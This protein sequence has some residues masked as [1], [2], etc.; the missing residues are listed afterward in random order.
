M[1]SDESS[2]CCTKG[3]KHSGTPSSEI[4]TFEDV[5]IYVA[6]PTAEAPTRAVIYLSDIFGMPFLNHKIIPDNF[7]KQGYLAI[8]PNLVGD[9]PVPF[10]ITPEYDFPSWIAVHNIEYTEP[11][12]EKAF[13]YTKKAFPSVTQFFSVGYCF[14]GKYV[15]RL[16]DEGKLDGG[17]IAHPSYVTDPELRAIKGPLSIAAAETDYL[18]TEEERHLTEKVLKEIGATYLLTLSSVEHG[19]AV[20]GDP[21][22]PV[23]MWA[24]EAAFYQAVQWFNRFSK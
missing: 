6:K 19:F 24:H 18:L 10:P 17:F 4:V 11:I 9:D 14:G 20:R 13:E 2:S 3:Y 16:L 7:A 12:I 1:A 8:L 5:D 23:T 15:V 22:D 21:S